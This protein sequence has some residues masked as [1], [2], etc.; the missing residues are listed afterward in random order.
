[1][2]GIPLGKREG[3][4][5]EFKRAA[6]LEDPF[7]VARELVAMCNAEG[8]E[9]WIG[10]VEQDGLAAQLE[11]IPEIEAARQRL[12]DYLVEVMEPDADGAE[13]Q[14]VRSNDGHALLVVRAKADKAKYP[15]AAVR[16]GLRY[17][18]V[19]VG[20]RVRPMTHAELSK[21][22]RDL[23]DGPSAKQ[24]HLRRDEILKR[25]KSV[26]WIGVQPLEP[27][28]IE[29][30]DHVGLLQDPS[31]SGN[32]RGGWTPLSR[33][34]EPR[35]TGDAVVLGNEDG[36]YVAIHEDG[37]CEFQVPLSQIEHG[38]ASRVL[39]ALALLEYCVSYLRLVSKVLEAEQAR[40]EVLIDFAFVRPSGWKLPAC[41]AGTH[42]EVFEHEEPRELSDVA[43]PRP[44]RI[45]ADR[46]IANPDAVGY[47]IVKKIYQW[48][49]LPEDRI[50]R[51]YDRF[52]ERLKLTD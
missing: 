28:E 2:S 37:R 17:F 31:R 39:H 13:P 48:F 19:R 36:K 4:R 46:L 38:S 18:G 27:L 40:S 41:P 52:T 33:H 45:D 47:R 26:L 32:R 22:T 21:K 23:D 9:I 29:V 35:T 50:P 12:R 20:D 24:L 1:M 7:D 16:K 42:G 34:R 14:I 51:Q 43:L 49:D 15:Y 3:Q 6:V 25:G 8:G 44:L 5:L 30:I 10:I 11:D